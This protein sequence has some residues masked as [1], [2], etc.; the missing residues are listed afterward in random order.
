MRLEHCIRR[1]LGLV[2]HRVRII[3]EQDDHLVAEI[4]AIE[5]R[6]P[7]VA[8]ADRRSSVRKGAPDV[9]CGGT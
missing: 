4:E 2:A 7:V 9:G 1:W 5:G 3:E 6:L 8:V